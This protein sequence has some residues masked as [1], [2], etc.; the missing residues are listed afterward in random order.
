MRRKQS[1]EKLLYKKTYTLW[2]ISDA[3]ELK[4]YYTF[5]YPTTLYDHYDK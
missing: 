3:N 4:N 1:Q 2:G 5:T